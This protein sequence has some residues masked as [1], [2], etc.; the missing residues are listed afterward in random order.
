MAT[1]TYAVPVKDDTNPHD[2][3]CP[4][5]PT[6]FIGPLTPSI[7]VKASRDY[8]AP[9]TTISTAAFRPGTTLHHLLQWPHKGAYSRRGFVL[10][11]LNISISSWNAYAT[12]LLKGTVDLSTP[13]NIDSIGDIYLCDPC[14]SGPVF[15]TDHGYSCWEPFFRLCL[16]RWLA[17]RELHDQRFQ[18]LVT[19]NF[20]L[21]LQEAGEIGLL[22][23]PRFVNKVLYK[24][25]KGSGFRRA[26]MDRLQILI[27]D[28]EMCKVY[29]HQYT[30]GV[31]KRMRNEV[32]NA[33]DKTLRGKGK[34]LNEMG[35]PFVAD[36]ANVW[37]T[38]TAIPCF[39]HDHGLVVDEEEEA[40]SDDD[41]WDGKMDDTDGDEDEDDDS[42]SDSDDD[43]GGDARGAATGDDNDSN[44]SDD[45]NDNDDIDDVR[46]STKTPDP[47]S[48][49]SKGSSSTLLENCAS[50]F[51][52]DAS[53]FD[54]ADSLRTTR[55]HSEDPE[56]CNRRYA[57][58][59]IEDIQPDPVLR[60]EAHLEYV[61]W[62]HRQ[63]WYTS[64][65]EDSL[66]MIISAGDLAAQERERQEIKRRLDGDPAG[67]NARCAGLTLGNIQPDPVFR[68]QAGWEYL[69]WR[70][71]LTI[72]SS[73]ATAS[74]TSSTTLEGGDDLEFHQ[75]GIKRKRA[76]SEDPEERNARYAAMTIEEI[77]PD[78]AVRKHVQRRY[79]I[80]KEERDIEMETE[81]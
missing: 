53:T 24:V 41:L 21:G 12:F 35:L 31:S 5:Q 73:A 77:Q 6:A 19:D 79:G 56:E 28:G 3:T 17:G 69:Q 70:Q 4:H 27:T 20:C 29:T 32:C 10:E 42:D 46:D 76:V 65:S 62:R 18:N 66:Q 16:T 72:S 45:S 26:L 50:S 7:L 1:M 14:V 39:Y 33:V 80:W 52:A 11:D 54:C 64:E 75:C 34:G 36:A 63:E 49:A 57:A 30:R 61:E 15:P 2:P 47:S 40:T 51:Q 68:A 38:V 8:D 23:S 81:M 78:E 37:D 58:M 22:P 44:N 9:F 48:P 74:E 55:F 71:G 43:D 60:V 13:K 59:T 67:R 25:P